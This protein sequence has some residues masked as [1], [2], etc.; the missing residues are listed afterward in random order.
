MEKRYALLISLLITLLIAGNYLYFKADEIYPERDIVV[1]SRVIDGDTVE[2]E[3]GRIIRLLNINTP[4]KGRAFSEEASNFL[5]QFE[6]Q[7]VEL[8]ITGVGKY[9]RILG[10]LY[11]NA[12][13]NLE[14]VKLGLA[15]QYL[16]EE[17][18]IDEFK[19]AEQEAREKGLGIWEKSEHYDCLSVEI[20]K[21]DEFVIIEDKCGVDFSSWTIKDESTK[22]YVFDTNWEGEVSLYSGEGVDKENELYWGRGNVWNDDKDSIFIRDEKGLLVYYDSYGY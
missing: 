2:L 1:I 7:A 15:H 20:N 16:G 17:N 11:G 12:Y 5:K 13:L 8:E 9:G 19:K 18:E 6:N 10:R 21:Y 4:E 3:D 14:L 22:N